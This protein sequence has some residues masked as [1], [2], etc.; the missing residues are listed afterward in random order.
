MQFLNQFNISRVQRLAITQCGYWLSDPAQIVRS[1]LYQTLHRMKD[2]RTLMLTEC[3]ELPFIHALN[4]DKNPYKVILCPR[5]EEIIFH[6]YLWDP[7]LVEELVGVAEGRA[8]RDAKL[9]A[10]KI[11][12]DNADA[13]AEEGFLSLR[14]HVKRVEC[15]FGYKLPELDILLSYTSIPE[16]YPRDIKSWIS[17]EVSG[18][19]GTD[20]G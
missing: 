18:S 5:L 8:L 2:L 6:T 11:V 9:S 3:G 10:I 14:K 7:S 20:I 1:T 4:P 16:G 12:S 19:E 17:T 15:R 13:L